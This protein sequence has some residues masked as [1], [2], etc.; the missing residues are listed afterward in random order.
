MLINVL[1]ETIM[2][3]RSNAHWQSQPGSLDTTHTDLA[4]PS[5]NAYGIPDLAHTPYTAI[6]EWLAP[7][8]TRIRSDQRPDDGAIHFFLDDYRFESVWSAPG[9]ALRYLEHYQTILSP[10]FS[11]YTNMPM[12]VQ[13]WNTYRNRWCGCYWQSLG[14]TV[15]P[16]VSW[17]DLESYDFCFLGIPQH[18]LVAVSSEGITTELD[19]P[20]FSR[21]YRTLI[22]TLAPSMIL[23]YGKL[24]PDLAELA[25]HRSYPTYWENIRK[26]RKHGRTWNQQLQHTP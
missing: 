20:L 9:K 5:Q 12:T 17:S 25:P 21:G 7:Y 4:F 16:T 13:L 1:Y 8:R 26:A 15:I 2:S 18:S 10:D 3:T 19:Y 22:E 14:Y 6:P 11:L 24:H 23:C